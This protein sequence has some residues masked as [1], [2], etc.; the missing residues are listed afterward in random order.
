MAMTQKDLFDFKKSLDG[1][2]KEELE[3]LEQELVKEAEM[4]DKEVNETV[5]DLPTE[6]YPAVAEAIRYFLDKQSVQ[7][8]YSL[9]MVA[10][11]DFWG[12]KPEKTI[13]YAQLDT[14]LRTLGGL[15]FTGYKEW[16]MVVAVNKFFEPLREKYVE[17]TTKVYDVAS[18]HNEVMNALGLNTP[19]TGQEVLILFV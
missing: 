19:V 9:A 3:A 1:K 14:I 4:V 17:V 2:S 5:F 18:K 12:E 15:Q 16:A 13:P 11:Y 6:N 7:W 10:M 8:Q